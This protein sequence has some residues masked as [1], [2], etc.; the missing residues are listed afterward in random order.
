MAGATL[1]KKFAKKDKNIED[2][3]SSFVNI[4]TEQCHKISSNVQHEAIHLKETHESSA[5]KR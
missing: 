2:W 1:P 3:L 4:R 5:E